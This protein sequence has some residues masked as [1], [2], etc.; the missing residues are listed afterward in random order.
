MLDDV[1]LKKKH[2]VNCIYFRTEE[3]LFAFVSNC[4]KWCVCIVKA[5]VAAH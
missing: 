5:P 1:E 3:S 2:Y 4:L